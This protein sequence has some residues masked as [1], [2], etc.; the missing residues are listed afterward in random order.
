M[1]APHLRARVPDRGQGGGDG[2]AG[3]AAKL[4]GRGDLRHHDARLLEALD[5]AK[6]A[7]QQRA[8]ALEGKR[9]RLAFS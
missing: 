6:V 2:P 7:R 4:G 5:D 1:A 8:G 3:Q 9:E